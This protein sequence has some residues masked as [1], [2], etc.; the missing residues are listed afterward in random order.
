MATMHRCV[1]SSCLSAIREFV[2]QASRDLDADELA[3]ADL[4]LA[5]DEICSNVIKHGYSGQGGRIEITVEPVAGGVQV[6]VRDWG[7]SF[8]PQAVPVP[9]IDAPLEERP[10]GGLGLFLVR[11]VMAKRAT[12]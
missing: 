7:K 5:V 3:I 6:T 4:E 8:D 2:A 11:Q 10:L 1:D 12:R 9:D